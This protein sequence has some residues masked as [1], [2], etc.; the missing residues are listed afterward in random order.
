MSVL[1]H[2]LH[3]EINYFVHEN[4]L[5]IASP[6]LSALEPFKVIVY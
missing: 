4:C 3:A 1:R 5:K 2:L 6:K